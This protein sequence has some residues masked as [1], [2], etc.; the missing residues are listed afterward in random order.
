LKIQFTPH[1]LF[2]ENHEWGAGVED[3]VQALLEAED[4]TPLRDKTM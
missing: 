2:D 1:D 3:R 4:N